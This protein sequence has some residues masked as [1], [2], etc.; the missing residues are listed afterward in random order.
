M[1]NACYRYAYKWRF[2]IHPDTSMIL[3]Y[4]EEQSKVTKH[5]ESQQMECGIQCNK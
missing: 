2:M 3:V 4:G 1:I 5:S